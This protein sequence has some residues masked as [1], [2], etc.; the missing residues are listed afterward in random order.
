M[1]LEQIESMVREALGTSADVRARRP[2]LFQVG[3]PAYFS[4]GDGANVFVREGED[5]SLLISDQG[6]TV[7][8]LGYTREVTNKVEEDL[9]R[10]AAAHGFQ[11][12][13]G[14][15]TA[16]IS[17]RELAGGVLGLVQVESEAEAAIQAAG[18]RRQ[19]AET[20]RRTVREALKDIFRDRCVLDFS[21]P[22]V[23]PNHDYAIDAVID[24][25][26]ALGV[27][28]VSNDAEADSALLRKIKLD[29]VLERRNHRRLWVAI[30]R[31]IAALGPR[32]QRKL[33]PEYE[34]APADRGQLERKLDTLAS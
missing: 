14:E 19:Q 21:D 17:K 28:A 18:S 10:L 33:L 25:P 15:L 9:S 3:V 24:G 29:P 5:G 34:L 20:F 26:R 12:V 23:D 7:M 31:D 32:A 30:P 6:A 22:V 27:Y 11:L 2:R 4:D 8:R 1:S 13:D 16:R